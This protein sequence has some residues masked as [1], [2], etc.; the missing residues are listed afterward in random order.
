MRQL[1]EQ[2]GLG[3]QARLSERGRQKETGRAPEGAAG[4]ISRKLMISWT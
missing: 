1:F 3:I 4:L 2:T